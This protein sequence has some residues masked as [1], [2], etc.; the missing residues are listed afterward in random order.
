MEPLSSLPLP[1]AFTNSETG[2]PFSYCMMCD[3]ALK[4]KQ[5]LVEK[6]IRNYKALGTR[7]VIFEFAMCLPCA[8]KMHFE[9]SEESRGRV[10]AFMSNHI[11]RKDYFSTEDVDRSILNCAVN[12]SAVEEVGEYSVYAL[13]N[14]SEITLGEFP[15]AL[16]GEAQDEIMKLL[17]AKSLEILDDFIG[18]HF[19]G[20]P[21]VIELLK[22]RPILV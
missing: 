22:K 2:E 4:D 5:Y 13:C 7:E 18:K 8:G 10:A 14:G 3:C 19:S 1:S 6:A 12:G 11:V 16:S 17:S 21:E 9:L 20:P 15:Y